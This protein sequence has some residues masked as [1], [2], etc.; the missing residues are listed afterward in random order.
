[1][2]KD[3]KKASQNREITLATGAVY[4]NFEEDPEFIGKYQGELRNEENDLIG[5]NFS[6]EK[7]EVWVIPNNYAIEKALNTNQQG[8]GLVKES[9]LFLKIIFLGKK[10]LKGGKTFSRF[11]ISLL[12]D[13]I[14]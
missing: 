9:G 10:E 2:G 8:I 1:M 7:M 11:K 5:F 3:E 12:P 6:D 4:W 14:A 13:K